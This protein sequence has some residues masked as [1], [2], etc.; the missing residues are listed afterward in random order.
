MSDDEALK[1]AE[2]YLQEMLKADDT[3]NFELFTQRYEQ[4]YLTGF[5]REKFDSDIEGMHRRNGMNCG[6]EFLATLRPANLDG[7]QVHRSVW[8]GIYEK[9]DAVIEF[10]VYQKSGEWYV[11]NSA[12]H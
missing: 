9:R 7:L 10:G 1:V 2:L 8:K 12:V 3:A 5:S 6:Y 4:K 11:I